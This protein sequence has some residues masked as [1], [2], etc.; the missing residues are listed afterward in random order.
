MWKHPF[1]KKYITSRF[2]TI[3]NRET[4]HRGVDY[5][6]GGGKLIK[7]ITNGTIERITW[8]DCLGWVVV[9]SSLSRKYFI[10]Y[11]HLACWKHGKNCKGPEAHKDGSTGLKSLRVGDDVLVGKTN[12]G[13]VGNT[14]SCSRGDHLHA[15]LGR[16]VDSYKI[17]VVMDLEKYIDEQDS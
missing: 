4:A 5:A 2:G 7:A 8:S 16:T 11:C 6:P 14:G 10:S 3:A 13:R 17:G 12:V 9:Q 1:S 15:T